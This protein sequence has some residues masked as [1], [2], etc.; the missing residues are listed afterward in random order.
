MHPLTLAN[1]TMYAFDEL[2]ELYQRE[3]AG[4]RNWEIEWFYDEAPYQ[5]VP[6][7]LGGSP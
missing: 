2:F 4:R 7:K 1:A 6:E 5:V 3:G